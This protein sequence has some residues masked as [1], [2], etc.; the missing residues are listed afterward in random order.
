MGKKN[1]YV[2]LGRFAPFHKGHQKIVDLTI[3]KYGLENIIMMI[4]SSD[5]YNQRTPY[6]Y[7]DRKM[8]IEAVYP[9]IRVMP[10][11]DMNSALVYFDG[12]TNDQWLAGLKQ[13]EAEYG[14]EFIFVGGSL[15]DLAILA[16]K[17]PIKMMT[18]RSEASL[19]MSATKVRE[20]LEKNDQ[21]SLATMLDSKVIPLAISGYAKFKKVI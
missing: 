2:Y 7:E 9:E 20:A 3:L 5:S 13:I 17:F 10:L 4:G 16:L 19:G 6:S 14:A 11:P 12:S 8:M 1:K 21:A 15:P 18:D